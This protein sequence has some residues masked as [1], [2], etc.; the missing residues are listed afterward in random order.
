MFW[1]KVSRQSFEKG[2]RRASG[3]YWW[4][5]MRDVPSGRSH[6]QLGRKHCHTQAHKRARTVLTQYK[7]KYLTGHRGSGKHKTHSIMMIPADTSHAKAHAGPICKQTQLPVPTHSV[8]SAETNNGSGHAATQLPKNVMV[9]CS[10]KG[11]S[12]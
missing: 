10:K 3:C 8:S 1:V 2:V 4:E 9:I 12:H 11:T 5:Q 7:P 6:V